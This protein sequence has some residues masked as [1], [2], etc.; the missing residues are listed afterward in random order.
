VFGTLPHAGG[1]RVLVGNFGGGVAPPIVVPSVSVAF[2]TT[3]A[4]RPTLSLAPIGCFSFFSSL[5]LVLVL[6]N[7]LKMRE[8]N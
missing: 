7:F 8:I 4:C 1:G 5:V 6:N 3:D 2:L